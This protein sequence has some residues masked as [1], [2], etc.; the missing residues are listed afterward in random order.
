MKNRIFLVIALFLIM[1]GIIG[2]YILA[3]DDKKGIS[4]KHIYNVTENGIENSNDNDTKNTTITVIPCSVPV[5]V[6]VKIGSGVCITT[7]SQWLKK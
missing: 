1:T 2:G 5:L 7:D 4:E 6:S 3:K